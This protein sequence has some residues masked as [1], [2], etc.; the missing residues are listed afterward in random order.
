MNILMSENL[1][2]RVAKSSIANQLDQEYNY[3]IMFGDKEAAAITSLSIKKRKDSNFNI[4]TICD[5]KSIFYMARFFTAGLVKNLEIR[6]NDTIIFNS[7][8]KIME[9]STGGNFGKSKIKI[10]FN[11][12]RPEKKWE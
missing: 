12:I 3:S 10:I 6:L 4:E 9:I 5:S 7:L 1:K 8:S 2:D 11:T